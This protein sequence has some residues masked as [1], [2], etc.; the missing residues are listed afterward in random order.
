MGEIKHTSE[1]IE[2]AKTPGSYE[3]TEGDIKEMSETF[4]YSYPSKWI[5]HVG[6]ENTASFSFKFHGQKIEGYGS[7]V[8]NGTK[9]GYLAGEIYGMYVDGVPVNNLNHLEDMKNKFGPLIK[10]LSHKI[11]I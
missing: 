8:E 5:N 10:K 11:S 6:F 9:Q 7:V 4:E 3:V 1:G 2:N